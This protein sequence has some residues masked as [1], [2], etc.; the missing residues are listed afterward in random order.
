MLQTCLTVAN[1]GKSEVAFSLMNNGFGFSSSS[2]LCLLHLV[3]LFIIFQ[4]YIFLRRYIF[5]FITFLTYFSLL[6]FS[7]SFV[8]YININISLGVFA[9]FIPCLISIIT[10][11]YYWYSVYRCLCVREKKRTRQ[12]HKEA[13]TSNSVKLCWCQVPEFFHTKQKMT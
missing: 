6:I 4:T 2:F 3:S 11:E 10:I 9:F 1:G 12:C 7:Y 13:D 5:N 8:T